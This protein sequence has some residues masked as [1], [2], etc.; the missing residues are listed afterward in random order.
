ADS[1]IIIDGAKGGSLA[2]IPEGA[3]LHAL[4]LCVDQRTVFSMNVE[5]PSLHRIPVKSVDADRLTIAFD[6]KAPGGLAGQTYQ[7]AKDAD[8]RLDGKA[9]KL[10]DVPAGAFVNVVL[11]VLGPT[12]RRIDTEGPQISEC[13]ISAVD[14]ARGTITLDDKAGDFAGMALA[15]Q[16]AT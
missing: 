3:S 12:A 11:S 1:E 6:D 16:G 14:V 2:A 7:V 4:I 9:G 8:I 5:G 13:G 10:V 15:A